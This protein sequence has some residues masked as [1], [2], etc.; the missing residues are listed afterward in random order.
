MKARM[1]LCTRVPRAF[2]GV[3][4]VF[5]FAAD[6]TNVAH[7][8]MAHNTRMSAQSL[9]HFAKRAIAS[10]VCAVKG[11][12]QGGHPLALFMLF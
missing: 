12:F 3:V 8:E 11:G 6:A 5:D 9:V 2:L 4:Q 7:S 10:G 1:R